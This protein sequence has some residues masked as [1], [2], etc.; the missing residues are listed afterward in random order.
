MT[1]HWEELLPVFSGSS[2]WDILGIF[3]PPLKAAGTNC[4]G[5]VQLL[6]MVLRAPACSTVLWWWCWA[7]GCAQM[8]YCA[9][10]FYFTQVMCSALW[11]YLRKV[12]AAAVGVSVHMKAAQGK[13]VPLMVLVLCRCCLSPVGSQFL[14]S[15]CP[16]RHRIASITAGFFFLEH[17]TCVWNCCFQLRQWNAFLCLHVKKYLSFKLVC[18][19]LPP[20]PSAV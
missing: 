18:S 19:S 12:S 20:P 17:P 9:Q 8:L 1:F 16:C 11:R 2:C 10:V 14:S 5:S 4:F 15:C 13:W 3:Y 7:R 6:G